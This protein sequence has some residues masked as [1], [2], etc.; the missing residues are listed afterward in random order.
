M[1]DY[2]Q[3]N[4]DLVRNYMIGAY[5]FVPFSIV[6]IVFLIVLC[7]R[8]IKDYYLK[9]SIVFYIIAMGMRVLLCVM[10]VT[11]LLMSNER[12]ANQTLV[13]L[14]MSFVQFQLPYYLFILV[15]TAVLFSMHTF[16][17]NLRRFLFP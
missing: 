10:L 7:L 8:K 11:I 4:P 14:K 1:E 2:I 5:A 6:F 15:G 17:T 3:A 9:H 12:E 13:E 16:Y